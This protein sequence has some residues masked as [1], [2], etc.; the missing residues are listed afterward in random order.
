MIPREKKAFTM[1]ELVI[2]VMVMGILV[3]IALPSFLRSATVSRAREA[4]S[5]LSLIQAGQ[6]I[7][8]NRTKT[9]LSDGNIANIN[10][11]LGLDLRESY[12]DYSANN[13]PP[14]N[15]GTATRGTCTYTISVAGVITGTASCPE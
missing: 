4:K 9:Y 6:K 13:A 15:V 12:W 5:A 11:N 2:V 10:S 7:Y 8:Y 3:S 1:T 14:N